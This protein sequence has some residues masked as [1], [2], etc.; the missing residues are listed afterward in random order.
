MLHS[1]ASKYRK[2]L[3]NKTKNLLK[4]G[5]WIRT[6]ILTQI[7]ERGEGLSGAAG[8]GEGG[9][10]DTELESLIS[11]EILTLHI[12]TINFAQRKKKDISQTLKTF[13][14]IANYFYVRNCLK[15]KSVETYSKI[16][17]LE[18]I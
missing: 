5:W 6:L 1:N 9:C 12:F 14:T 18:R 8:E 4:I 15:T 2:N 17:H 7:F 16:T 11:L 3:Q 13:E 10:L